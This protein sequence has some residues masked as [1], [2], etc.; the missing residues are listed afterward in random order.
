[1]ETKNLAFFSTSAIEGTGRGVVIATGDR[2]LMGRI[3]GLATRLENTE[4]SL[5]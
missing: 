3:A 2:T 5:N 4:V 1:M